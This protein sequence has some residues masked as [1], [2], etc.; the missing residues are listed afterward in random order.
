[1]DAGLGAE[2]VLGRQDD[3]EGGDGAE[4]V[5]EVGP[6]VLQDRRVHAVVG[7]EGALVILDPPFGG[8]VLRWGGLAAEGGGEDEGPGDLGQLLLADMGR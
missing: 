4:G 3:A 1:M 5:W 2:Q 7:G 8:V 6:E